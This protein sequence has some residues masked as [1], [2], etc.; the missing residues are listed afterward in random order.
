MPVHGFKRLGRL[1]R[2][3]GYKR[4]SK[5]VAFTN[6]VAHSLLPKYV[7][8]RIAGANIP[9]TEIDKVSLIELMGNDKNDTRIFSPVNDFRNYQSAWGWLHPA[10]VINTLGHPRLRDNYA[11]LREQLTTTYSNIFKVDISER[12]KWYYAITQKQPEVVEN[13]ISR[14]RGE[15]PFT[16]G[17]LDKIE[18]N[19]EIKD[20]NLL[21]VLRNAET[22]WMSKQDFMEAVAARD[23][24]PYRYRYVD[25]YPPAACVPAE[26]GTFAASS[27]PGN[28]ERIQ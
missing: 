24:Q 3:K 1:G 9:T 20:Y 13:A 26:T 16:C 22:E 14:F 12:V 4:G 7:A 5:T 11:L 25:V 17:I 18:T 6:F 23:V 2:H 28:F 10:H 19:G 27:Q 21:W 15:S 8:E